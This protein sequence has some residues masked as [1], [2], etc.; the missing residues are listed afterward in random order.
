MAPPTPPPPTPTAASAPAPPRPSP[1]P[2]NPAN[3][4]Q[5]AAAAAPPPSTLPTLPTLPAPANDHDNECPICTTP[6]HTGTEPETPIR[7]SK[8]GHEFGLLCAAKWLLVPGRGNGCPICRD[9]PFPRGDKQQVG[10]GIGVG[11][12]MGGLAQEEVFGL[13]GRTGGGRGGGGGRAGIDF[14]EVFDMGMGGLGDILDMS[15]LNPFDDPDRRGDRQAGEQGRGVGEVAGQGG[16]LGVGG[17][18]EHVEVEWT[19]VEHPSGPGMGVADV[20]MRVVT[21]ANGGVFMT[22]DQIV[23]HGPQRG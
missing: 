7:L 19:R 3:S 10:M 22:V 1:H 15:W 9:R 2:T 21:Q 18:G 11:M 17:V 20:G 8:C 5:P 13:I 23:N 16:G 12:G 6:Y 4:S 14:G